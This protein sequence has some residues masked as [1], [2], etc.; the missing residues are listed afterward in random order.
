MW[1]M[2]DEP[3]GEDEAEGEE[4]EDEDKAGEREDCNKSVVMIWPKT[5]D[6]VPLYRELH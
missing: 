3:E 4:K 6:Y 5:E 2:E 1:R